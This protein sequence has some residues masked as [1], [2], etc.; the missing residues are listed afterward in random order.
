MTTTTYLEMTDPAQLQPKTCSDRR[1]QVLQATTPQWQVNRFLYQYVGEPWAWRD[2]LPW[3]DEQWKRYVEDPALRTFLALYDGSVA[4]YFELLR[5]EDEVEIAY[6][7]LAW[8]F[9]GKGL[10]GPLLTRALQEAWAIK[11]RRVWVHT[12]TLDHPASPHNY[13]ARGMRV[14]KTEVD[15]VSG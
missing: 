13:Q 7:G 11:P 12:C 4:G 15:K 14:Y 2:K 6:L 5:R 9:I 1:F 3:S 10:G 8:P